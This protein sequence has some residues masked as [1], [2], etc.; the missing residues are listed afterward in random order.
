MHMENLNMNSSTLQRFTERHR[1]AIASVL[2]LL[3]IS[4][5]AGYE[6]WATAQGKADD[7]RQI[8]EHACVPLAHDNGKPD[9][10][11]CPGNVVISKPSPVL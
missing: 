6:H 2:A 10:I 9:R 3:F 8:A 5:L 1:A 4:A 7:D 11:L